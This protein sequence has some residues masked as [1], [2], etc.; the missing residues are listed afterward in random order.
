MAFAP[1]I[2]S[3][4]RR[5]L[6]VRLGDINTAERTDYAVAYQPNTATL[7]KR[8][9]DVFWRT[10]DLGF[11]AFGGPPVHFQIFHQRFVDGRGKTPWIDEQ[12]VNALL[13]LITWRLFIDLRA[14]SR[15]VRA[16]PSTSRPGI[17]EDAVQ[18]RAYSRGDYTRNACI[19]SMVVS[20]RRRNV[21]LV[22]RRRE[23]RRNASESSVR[24]PI[25]DQRRN[26]GDHR[27][28]CHPTRA[29]GDHR[30][31]DAPSCCIWRLLRPVL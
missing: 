8:L 26:S 1:L 20:W 11:T 15:I 22:S 18:Y 23:N 4:F 13:S 31:F 9:L 10:F 12:T 14:V 17:D 2:S 16:L 27:P 28:S 21:R 5:F 3:V 25:W 29:K 24:R 6:R 19:F 7:S 30:P